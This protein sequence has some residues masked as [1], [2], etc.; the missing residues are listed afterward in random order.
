VP[1]EVGEI[2]PDIPQTRLIFTVL[3]VALPMVLIAVAACYP[4]SLRD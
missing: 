4:T 2:P 1:K 3:L